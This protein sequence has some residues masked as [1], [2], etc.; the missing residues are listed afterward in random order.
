[1]PSILPVYLQQYLHPFMHGCLPVKKTENI[2]LIDEAVDDCY[3]DDNAGIRPVH[4]SC[5]LTFCEPL[6]LVNTH[7]P[8]HIKGR[9]RKRVRV[10]LQTTGQAN[11]I[12]SLLQHRLHVCLHTNIRATVCEQKILRA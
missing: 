12:S 4:T 5:S 11:H 10:C 3:A 6:T 8:T 1:M 7:R 2:H 9:E